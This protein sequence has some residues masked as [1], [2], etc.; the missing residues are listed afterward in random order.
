MEKIFDT[1]ATE[2]MSTAADKIRKDLL[3]TVLDIWGIL[4]ED[5]Q[6]EE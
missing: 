5:S 3:V 4:T 1:S 6:E 2:A